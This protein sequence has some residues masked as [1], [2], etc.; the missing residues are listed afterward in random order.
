MAEQDDGLW[1]KPAWAKGES[2]TTSSSLL[3][4]WLVVQGVECPD[5]NKIMHVV[6]LVLSI[7]LCCSLTFITISRFSLSGGVKLRSTGRADVMKKEGNLAAPVTFTPYKSE[8]HSNKVA[9]QS[10]LRRTEVGEAAKQGEDLAAPITF[11]PFKNNDHSNR[12]ANPEILAKSEVGIAAKE[13]CDLAAPITFTPYKND[14]HSNPVAKPDILAATD[15]GEK[16]KTNG[17]LAMPITNIRDEMR[18]HK[19]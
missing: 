14:D 1:E 16:M 9:N 17:N 18:K 12:V 10:K 6:F 2:C 7:P 4:E 3:V 8:D 11:T 19:V 15:L 5:L 13:G